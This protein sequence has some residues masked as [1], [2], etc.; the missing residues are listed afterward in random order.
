M[1]RL[2]LKTKIR[3]LFTMKGSLANMLRRQTKL[4]L[5]N[6]SMIYV[7]KNHFRGGPKIWNS[8]AVARR[9]RY[10]INRNENFLIGQNQESTLSPCVWK[11]LSSTPTSETPRLK[12][13][14]YPK[15][16]IKELV[17]FDEV[18]DNI[19]KESPPYIIFNC[20]LENE[21]DNTSL[22][23][24]EQK[25][26]R[27]VLGFPRYNENEMI[28]I[29]LDV[30]SLLQDKTFN[31]KQNKELISLTLDKVFG[32]TDLVIIGHTMSTG[33]VSLKKHLGVETKNMLDM[34]IA[35][36]VFTGRSKNSSISDFFNVCEI[37]NIDAKDNAIHRWN[38]ELDISTFLS[39]DYASCQI[40]V[41]SFCHSIN[42]FFRKFQN[43]QN[44]DVPEL[45]GLSFKQRLK[46]VQQ[47]T[48][49]R[50]RNLFS[51]ENT[52]SEDN[53]DFFSQEVFEQIANNKIHTSTKVEMFDD[54]ESIL[55]L[56]PIHY[57]DKLS[58]NPSYVSTLTGESD[59][60]LENLRDIVMEV[61]KRPYAFFGKQQREWICQDEKFKLSLSDIEIL[62]KPLLNRFGPNNR[63]VLDG[64]LHR[65]SCMRSK[66]DEIYSLT[67]RIGRAIVGQCTMIQDILFEKTCSMTPK[68]SI[69]I[70]GFPGTGKTTVIRD[71]V[72]SLSSQMFNVI[73]V[74]TSN[75]ICGDG[76][77]LHPSVGMARR[78]MVPRLDEQGQI[79]IEA[80]QNHTPDVIVCDEIGRLSE[81]KATKTVK[82]RGVRCIG[83]AHGNLRSLVENAELNGLIGGVEEVTLGDEAAREY[84]RNHEKS[85][86]S[87]IVK[88]RAGKPLFDVIVELHPDTFN[89]WTV[90]KN[91]STAV[92]DIL[93]G[94]QY[95]AEIRRREGKTDFFTKERILC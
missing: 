39:Q 37:D 74:D 58:P 9:S 51:T 79:L 35:Y 33:I 55:N 42:Q 18:I 11:G 70:M 95:S 25:L 82:E 57:R 27:I 29:V 91:V 12:P 10:C 47:A 86:F 22:T 4:L 72:N 54:I 62:S 13:T 59:K 94:K 68:P 32:K 53:H 31:Q 89:E 5:Q 84:Q 65:I 8:N 76:L 14:A 64:S 24:I 73:V 40:Y 49:V 61:G 63:A 17:E 6:S 85:E 93:V 20:S 67:Y 60:N 52:L 19:V 34:Q 7:P 16:I 45:K 1:T 66:T 75:E 3:K 21:N 80:V 30:T 88:Q 46:I 2:S 28:C 44:S 15:S 71:I 23:H 41:S 87:K 78:M 50:I 56:I 69:L 90:V 92:D 26:G 83:S 77:I 81:V 48:E 43:T 36:E 38:H